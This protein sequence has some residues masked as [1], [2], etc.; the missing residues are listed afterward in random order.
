MLNIILGNKN[1]EIWVSG[2]TPIRLQP[3]KYIPILLKINLRRTVKAERQ[4][5][6]IFIKNYLNE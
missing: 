5:D 4:N 1:K 6:N 2:P 3:V